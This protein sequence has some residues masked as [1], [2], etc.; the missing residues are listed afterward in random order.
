MRELFWQ[1]VRAVAL[2]LACAA[3][4]IALLWAMTALAHAHFADHEQ[5]AQLTPAQ[6]DWLTHQKI[7]GQPEYSCCSVADAEQVEEDIRDGHYYV[8]AAACSVDAN[9]TAV[10]D[11]AVI[12][13]PNKYGQP[14]VWWRFTDG[15]PIP[16]C[17]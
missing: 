2:L 12:R 6:R 16:R 4:L 7:P 3:I 1:V 5:W 9:W 14:V 8:C 15:R 11:E 13:A 10:P 17:F